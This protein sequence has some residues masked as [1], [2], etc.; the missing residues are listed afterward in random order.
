MS[1][2]FKACFS[3]S[4]WHRFQIVWTKALISYE[5]FGKNEYKDVQMFGEEDRVSDGEP[6]GSA[7]GD[8]RWDP[9]SAEASP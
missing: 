3:F 4:C 2:C 5:G 9:E 6:A 7:F 8:S 1:F